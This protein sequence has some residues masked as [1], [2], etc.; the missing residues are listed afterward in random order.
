MKSILTMVVLF[1]VTAG[2]LWL[3]KQRLPVS[4]PAYCRKV[5]TRWAVRLFGY[6][7]KP[8]PAFEGGEAFC[9]YVR[10]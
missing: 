5:L 10:A 7:K 3:L 8:Q 9:V 6:E 2:L 1:A 4:L